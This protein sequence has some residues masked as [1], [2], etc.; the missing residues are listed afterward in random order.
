MP[1]AS[2]YPVLIPSRTVEALGDYYWPLGEGPL[3]RYYV[4]NQPKVFATELAVVAGSTLS[5][6]FGFL[7]SLTANK[8][9]LHSAAGEVNEVKVEMS[10][11]VIVF[12]GC[13]VVLDGVS[14]TSG[15]DFITSANDA[16]EDGYRGPNGF[17]VITSTVT[18]NIEF[19]G[20]DNARVVAN[21]WLEPFWN[22]TY[23]GPDGEYHWDVNTDQTALQP[24]DGSGPDIEFEG[25]NQVNSW[26][27]M[28]MAEPHEEAIQ[29]RLVFTTLGDV[30]GQAASLRSDGAGNSMQY[31]STVYH[32][33]SSGYNIRYDSG[34]T[35]ECI[36]KIDSTVD[37][38]AV[39]GA[40]APVIASLSNTTVTSL[41]T[42]EFNDWDDPATGLLTPVFALIDRNQLYSTAGADYADTQAESRG[43]TTL[44]TGTTYHLLGTI[45]YSDNTMELWVNGVS[46]GSVAIPD[47]VLWFTP[48]PVGD[49]IANGTRSTLIH[50]GA[51]FFDGAWRG[52]DSTIQDVKV[53]L[54]E[55]DDAFAVRQA[56]VL[57]D[58]SVVPLGP[59]SGVTPGAVNGLLTST[60]ITARHIS[61]TTETYDV[62]I[63]RNDAQEGERVGTEPWHHETFD[64]ANI[65]YN[66]FCT[67]YTEDII[68]KG[69]KLYVE[70]VADVD[71]VVGSNKPYF[72][73][74]AAG[75]ENPAWPPGFTS[76]GWSMH[77]DLAGV[78]YWFFQID[79]RHD[80]LAFEIGDIISMAVDFS[81]S[82][83]AYIDV[84]IN[85]I[86]Q[87]QRAQ[88]FGGA[89]PYDLRPCASIAT[90]H[91]TDNREYGN[92][93]RIL[94]H[95]GVQTYAPPAGFTALE[96]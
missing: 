13:T 34:F 48:G 92:T 12:T 71:L 25:A 41:W 65:V 63:T 96:T 7:T 44:V 10:S 24:E 87:Y 1:K 85:G 4:S 55:A 79:V 38:G 46:Q 94:T 59:A 36:A 3:H 28:V 20:G 18:S 73:F 37:Q 74:Q 77:S 19:I 80:A 76:D 9:L 47:G 45:R 49:D 5:F 22:V 29:K 62:G 26:S 67:I 69:S 89:T 93:S 66:D 83:V 2:L 84:Y 51:R 6:S 56:S 90:G 40:I 33:N 27:D 78:G 68:P 88:F 23:S 75:R 17:I 15:V 32:H 43:A 86:H 21:L 30:A 14:L 16:G 52:G 61:G 91:A 54:L 53:H 64:E 42:L 72:G 60:T 11:S 70:F 58:A 95:Q 82:L 31:D 39:D 8:V 50:V 35:V 57:L 81:D